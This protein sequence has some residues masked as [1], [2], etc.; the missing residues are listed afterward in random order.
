M[1]RKSVTAVFIIFLCL[2]VSDLLA[3]QPRGGTTDRED[4]VRHVIW[5]DITLE[6]EKDM[7]DSPQNIEIILKTISGQ[8]WGRDSVA[9]G[10]RYRFNYVPN[11]EYTLVVM[12]EDKV[13]MQEH[14]LIQEQRASDRRFDIALALEGGD[15][16]PP[17]TGLVYAR[18][19]HLQELFDKAQEE[20]SKDPKKAITYLGKIVKADPDDF[21]AWT[22]LGTA[23]FQRGK[24]KEA[25][26]AYENAVKAQPEFLLALINLS[27]LFISKKQPEE[28]LQA[29]TRAVQVESSS[30]EA[31]YLLGEAYLM[32]KKGSKAVGFLNQAIQL[33]P[34]GM[35]EVHLRLAALYDRAGYKNLAAREYQLFLEKKPDHKDREKMK[36]YITENAS[37]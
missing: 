28:A 24:E 13:I 32:A 2:Q 5:G 9:P 16:K 8:T 1:V 36:M 22:E 18:E 19:K 10:G 25:Q 33:D 21:E 26:R 30:A 4:P 37:P 11:G 20:L 23:Y 6:G 3:Q 35:A 17:E 31:N 7:K 14:L 12:V 34:V 27:K 29:A 15:V